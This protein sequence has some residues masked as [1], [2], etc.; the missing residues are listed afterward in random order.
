MTPFMI[1]SRES[2]F[3]SSP[4]AEK[5]IPGRSSSIA[6]W[7]AKRASIHTI[8]IKENVR[9]T[10]A[11]HPAPF[12]YS[13]TQELV[14]RWEQ[15]KLCGA[16]INILLESSLL[17][18][19]QRRNMPDRHNLYVSVS[20]AGVEVHESAHLTNLELRE[21]GI[22]IS[23]DREASGANVILR[24]RSEKT[25][26][27]RMRKFV[28]R[29]QTPFAPQPLSLLNLWC[30]E[31]WISDSV[32][33]DSSPFDEADLIMDGLQ[34]VA[35]SQQKHICIGLPA[36]TFGPLFN[37]LVTLWAV[38]E[39]CF[40]YSSGF[41]WLAALIDLS[42]FR[43]EALQNYSSTKDHVYCLGK[44]MEGQSWLVTATM[45]F[46]LQ[47]SGRMKARIQAELH[48]VSSVCVTSTRRPTSFY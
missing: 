45:T 11:I 6:D 26:S 8:Q 43:F 22:A 16:R 12:V 32:V 9:D 10:P 18:H 48:A 20:S 46:K 34:L 39:D 41:F 38:S 29:L 36:T 2:L 5:A 31:F 24:G 25:M 3:P 23:Q 44:P 17:P 33:V 40:T 27:P 47:R 42:K 30:T 1:P 37:T 7:I 28:A 35:D 13:K 4:F 15:T 19:G 14:W 21:Y